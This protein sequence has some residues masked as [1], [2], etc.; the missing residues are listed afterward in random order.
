M[1]NKYNL[2]VSIMSLAIVIVVLSGVSYSYFVYNKDIADVSLSSGTINLDF[3][4]TENTTSVISDQPVSDNLGMIWKTY[5]E[6]TVNGTV[7]EEAILYELEVIPNNGNTIDGQYVK[8]YLTEVINNTETP[9]M[10][11]MKYSEL[12]DSLANNGKGMYQEILTGNQDGTSKNT[13]HVYRLRAWL[14]DDY[15]NSSGGNFN[16]SIYT[17]AYNINAENYRKVTFKFDDEREEALS[18]YVELGKEYGVLPIPIRDGHTFKGWR[19]S[20]LPHEYQEVEYIEST[21]TQWI[22]TGYKPDSN[23]SIEMKAESTSMSN[24]A[25]YCA[26]TDYTQDTYT[27]FLVNG[28]QLRVDYGTI[29]NTIASYSRNNF[30]IYKQDKNL[31]YVDN[32]YV[33]SLSSASFIT[34]YNM[35]LF[36]SHRGTEN[37]DNIGKTLK[38]YYAKIWDNGVMVRNMIPCYRKSDGKIGMYDTVNNVFYNNQGTSTFLKGEDVHDSLTEVTSTTEVNNSSDHTLYAIWQYNPIVIF[39]ANGGTVDTQTKTVV[40]GE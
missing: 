32:N 39:D 20:V 21:G 33:T 9:L 34:S 15:K 4:K 19:Q 3:S 30:H 37:L 13:T 12:Y 26:R 2:I 40:Y 14:S 29:Q 28:E 35:Y 5:L 6:F 1:K 7:D 10:S 8:F 17:Y 25:L 22:D 27:A 36:A 18:K 11:P 31:I 23:T 24:L 38:V 16:Y